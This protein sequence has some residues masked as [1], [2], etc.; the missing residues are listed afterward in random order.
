MH[1]FVNQVRIVNPLICMVYM[2]CNI[3]CVTGRQT[4]WLLDKSLLLIY[5]ELLLCACC[6]RAVMI[7]LL[8]MFFVFLMTTLPLPSPIPYTA[9]AALHIFPAYIP[10]YVTSMGSTAR[11][12]RCCALTGWRWRLLTHLQTRRISSCFFFLFGQRP[13]KSN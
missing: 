3:L 5:G 8:P 1:V 12:S 10:G 6:W 11:E 2:S 7:S 9:S 4:C 13:Q